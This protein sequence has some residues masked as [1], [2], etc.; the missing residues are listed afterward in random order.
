M[1]STFFDSLCVTI[2]LHKVSRPP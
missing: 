2:L 1:V